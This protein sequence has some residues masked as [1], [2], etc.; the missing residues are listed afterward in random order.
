MAGNG[1]DWLRGYVP[2][3]NSFQI[4]QNALL[5]EMS[6][7]ASTQDG[8][9][10]NTP[11]Q[12]QQPPAQALP[13]QRYDY[14]RARS[15]MNTNSVA[16]GRLLS[17]RYN[18]TGYT[19]PYMDNPYIP[20]P[21]EAY[22]HHPQS[23]SRA[24]Q[25]QPQLQP[26][27]PHPSGFRTFKATGQPKP[28]LDNASRPPKRKGTDQAEHPGR[29]PLNPESLHWAPQYSDLLHPELNTEQQAAS[30]P[31]PS[32]SVKPPVSQRL[33]TR[34]EVSRSRPEDEQSAPEA[35][36]SKAAAPSTPDLSKFSYKPQN[37]TNENFL[38][39]RVDL[40]QPLNDTDAAVKPSYGPQTIASDILIA[41]G[42]HPTE[43]CLNHHLTR[44]RDVFTIVGTSS[45]LDTFR[46][47][48]VDA[49]GTQVHR[50]KA[51]KKHS[52]PATL[53]VPPKHSGSQYLQPSQPAQQPLPANQNPSVAVPRDSRP[54]D[55][56][57][58]QPAPV[59]V[60][61][62]TQSK[63]K[64]NPLVTVQL[65]PTTPDLPRQQQSSQKQSPESQ[66]QSR[67]SQGRPRGRPRQEQSVEMVGTKSAPRVEVAIPPSTPES[68][69][70]YA[71]EWKN[72][73][74]ELH[75]LE[76]LRKHVLKVHIPYTLT[77][78]WLGCTCSDIMAAAQLLEHVKTH[79]IGPL[80]WK[81]GDGPA[82]HR[83]GEETL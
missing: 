76:L 67:Q 56:P 35:P 50:T 29:G 44:L 4:L 69:P 80:A 52:S 27:I 25:P 71:C 12:Q 1:D 45:D 18:Q 78:G 2:D 8:S 61:A 13:Q 23:I 33:N 49:P 16:L 82:M 64:P 31:V 32:A 15:M 17:A 20:P 51:A 40:I 81:L 6:G 48:I 63:P 10:P 21:Q 66:P 65:P 11:G 60:S 58:S 47:D 28:S 36:P 9:G 62:V 3:E 37:A 79:H 74:A 14:A 55:T 59:R 53:S 19:S 83:S 70:V 7:H 46:W 38:R 73:P 54:K 34:P 72:C 57:P 5:R 42:R 22:M 77:C 43:P 68:Y 26:Q 39:D 41:S 24:Y 30:F 75:N